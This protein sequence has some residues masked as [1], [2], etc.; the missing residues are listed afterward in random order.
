MGKFSTNISKRIEHTKITTG[1]CLICG[2]HGPLSFDHVPPQG[3]IT[4]TKVE[5]LHITEAVGREVT[6]LNG[7]LSNNGSKFRTICRNCNAGPLGQNDIEIANVCNSLKSKVKNHLEHSNAPYSVI[8]TGVNSTKFARAMIGHILSATSIEECKK[9][10]EYS[11]Y[12]QPL[13]NFVLGDDSAINSTHDIYYWFY[14]FNRHLSAKCVAFRNQGHTA[15]LSLLSFFPL[16]FMVTEKNKGI[17]PTHSL[18]LSLSDNFLTLDLSSRG[19]EFAEFPFHGLQ[20]DQIMSL[21]DFQTII[22]YPVGR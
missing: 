9:Q 15:I 10:P 6:K 13:K 11:P 17:Y 20:R 16:A 19:F 3:A 2:T 4:L 14:P 21:V 1:Y 22:S 7:V 18:Q 12:F 8:R 5:Q